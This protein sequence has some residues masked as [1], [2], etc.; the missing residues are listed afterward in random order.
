MPSRDQDADDGAGGEKPEPGQR[1]RI[2]PRQQDLQYD[3]Q[4]APDEG[5]AEGEGEAEEVRSG[6]AISCW[7]FVVRRL[8]G[9]LFWIS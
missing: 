5:R 9:Q 4:S 8:P 1:E 7:V 3:R 6:D 2:Q